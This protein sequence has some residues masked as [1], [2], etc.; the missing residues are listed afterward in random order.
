[1]KKTDHNTVSLAIARP[2]I[3]RCLMLFIFIS[4]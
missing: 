2:I 1:M 4:Y 3:S